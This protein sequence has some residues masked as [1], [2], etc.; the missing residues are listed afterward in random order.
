MSNRLKN[1]LMRTSIISA[2]LGLAAP[3]ALAAVVEGTVTAGGIPIEGAI[4]SN[5]AGLSTSTR[6]DGSYRFSNISEGEHTLTV[7]YVGT[8]SVSASITASDA[9]PTAYNFILGDETRMMDSTLVVGQRGSLL[10]G[11]NQQRA[12]DNLIAVLSADALGQFPDQN[13]A[14]SA[15]RIAG[16]SVANDQGEGRFVNIRGLDSGLN[17]TSVNG[18]NIPA[19]E[20]GTRAVAL[21]VID[22]D[23]LDS[24]SISKS[25]TPDMDGEGLGGTIDI[26]TMSAFDKDGLF[27]KA[28]ADAIYSDSSEEFTPK[29]SLTASK[30]FLNDT[31]GI[32]GSLAYNKR[33]F[34]TQN[35]EGDGWA[36]AD[37]VLY[38]EELELRL[39]E[40]ERERIST[41]L[42]FDYRLGSNTE[43]YLRTLYN[44]FED[45]EIRHRTEFKANDEGL[46]DGD[47][48]AGSI[49][50]TSTPGIAIFNANADSSDDYVIEVD[51][52]IKNR[53]ETQ[54][55]WS[56][57]LGG[58]TFYNA[59]T[60][61]YQVAYSRAEEEEPGRLDIEFRNKVEGGDGADYAIA[62]NI[63]DTALPVIDA[64]SSSATFFNAEDFA[65]EGAETTDGLAETNEFAA[66]FDIKRD[67]AVFG[68]PGFVKG[69]VKARLRDKRYDPTVRVYGD[70][71]DGLSSTLADF[72]TTPDYV[73][74]TYG[75]T[76]DEDQLRSFFDTNFNAFEESTTDSALSSLGETYKAFENIY[77]TYLMA[78]MDFGS[79]LLTYGAR[80][81]ATDFTGKGFFTTE[82]EGLVEDA[83]SGALVAGEAEEGIYAEYLTERNSYVDFL[84][85][86]NAK[87]DINKDI[88]ARAAYYASI[89]RPSLKQSTPASELELN[90]DNEWEAG[91][92]G[93]PE[94]NRMQA[95]NLD[96]ALEYYPSNTGVLSVGFFMKDIRNTIAEI[97][98]TSGEYQAFGLTFEEATFFENLNDATVVGLEFNYQQSFEDILPGALGGLVVGANYTILDSSTT[99]RDE[100]G[101]TRSIPLPKTSE[102]IAN[103]VLGYDKYGLDLRA[104]LSY[105]SEYL[106]EIDASDLGADRYYKGRY[107][108]DLTGKYALTDNFKIVGELSNVTDEPEHAV[109]KTPY[110]HALSQYDEYGYT[111]KLGLR[112]TY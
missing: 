13:V 110:G 31:L 79:T 69:G 95:H 42:N 87:F 53:T 30:T 80:V 104:A 86:L 90:D 73:I 2:A 22:A 68:V 89:A 71:L 106:D 67:G 8:D 59:L 93:N 78:Q 28:K 56:V 76:G 11:I 98:D 45:V 10:S 77:A 18:V 55:I 75:P 99:Y 33:D 37:G 26:K 3:A 23:I 27:V 6:A 82:F 52:D 44:S 34:T 63:A 92:I 43:L 72:A 96:A 103:F 60:F 101:N 84:P 58:S 88:V 16:I 49:F 24:I 97:V 36:F 81:E 17:L 94:L 65:Y 46:E 50:D 21:D 105:R 107:Q 109:F 35:K 1:T 102:N 25:K 41:A 64:G 91:F 112:Y 61:D 57:Q 7:S 47:V 100:E 5:E 54:D 70:D 111:A 40:I 66:R 12:A 85:S 62:Y 14:E 48:A 20:S 51:R 74:D 4:V 9:T 83:P 32:A 15:R 19:P 39:Y 29:V 38:P 108:L